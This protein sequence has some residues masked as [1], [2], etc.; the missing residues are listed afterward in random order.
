MYFIFLHLHLT[1]IREWDGRK[2]RDRK[3]EE[4]ILETSTHRTKRSK[5]VGEEGRKMVMMSHE[6][7]R[8]DV[9][10][11]SGRRGAGWDHTASLLSLREK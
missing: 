3:R 5:H 4:E 2:R 9:F 10:A 7:G 11:R 1:R 6:V 8:E